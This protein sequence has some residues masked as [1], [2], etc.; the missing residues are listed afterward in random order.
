MLWA[1]FVLP[2]TATAAAAATTGTAS[3][4]AGLLA[5]LLAGTGAL[6]TPPCSATAALAA[7]IAAV[8]VQEHPASP[9][10]LCAWTGIS[11]QVFVGKRGAAGTKERFGQCEVREIAIDYW[12]SLSQAQLA[13]GLVPAL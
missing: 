1:T 6:S 5:G 4:P 2:N 9:R 7:A 3:S 12:S 13:Y 10:E 8:S 11:S